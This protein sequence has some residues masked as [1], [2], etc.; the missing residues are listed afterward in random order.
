M[1]QRINAPLTSMNDQAEEEHFS[2]AIR[3]QHMMRCVQY[4]INM[5]KHGKLTH[6]SAHSSYFIVWI[7]KFL[8]DGILHA[9]KRQKLLQEKIGKR[10]GIACLFIHYGF[11]ARDI[12]KQ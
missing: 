10:Q 7:Y 5:D 6:K 3:Y 2:C 9:R 8:K 11:P 4:I 1:L 12:W